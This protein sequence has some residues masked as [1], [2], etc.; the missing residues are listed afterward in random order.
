MPMGSRPVS[1]P[2]ARPSVPNRRVGEGLHRSEMKI[3]LGQLR[4][5]R[6]TTESH[7]ALAALDPAH[8]VAELARDPDIMVLALR[9][10]QDIGLLVAKGR[11]P[12]FVIS[13]EFGVRLGGARLVGTNPV[14]KTDAEHR[15]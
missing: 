2:R 15:G 1:W 3:R 4:N 9:H 6:R 11:L 7:H 14:I 5:F 12:T 8:L 10:M 13:E